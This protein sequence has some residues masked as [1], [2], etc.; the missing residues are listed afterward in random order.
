L[1]IVM[2]LVQRFQAAKRQEFME[3]EKQFTQL[4]KRGILPQG[5]RLL[6]LASRDPGNTL[7]WQSRFPSLGAAKECLQAFET[8]PEHEE[9][10]RK[11][12]PLFEDTWVEFYEVMNC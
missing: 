9:L 6:P 10:A 2:R 8:S 3:L 1:A 7:I 12:T 4:E 11:Q 5:E